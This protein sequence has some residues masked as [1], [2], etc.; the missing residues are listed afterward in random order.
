MIK[1][2][3]KKVSQS[4]QRVFTSMISISHNNTKHTTKTLKSIHMSHLSTKDFGEVTFNNSIAFSKHY[5]KYSFFIKG[6]NLHFSLLFFFLI[7]TMHHFSSCLNNG[8]NKNED[9]KQKAWG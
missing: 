1:G 3:I 2:I 6:T 5:S 9:N 8:L 4:R 7:N